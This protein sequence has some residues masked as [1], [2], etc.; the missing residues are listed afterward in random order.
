[1]KKAIYVGL[2]ISAL[3][4]AYAA[5]SYHLTLAPA[6]HAQTPAEPS[7]EQLRARVADQP[8]NSPIPVFA[9]Y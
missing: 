6:A 1:M 5:G 3:A 9:K 8:V 2:A 4:V 7:L